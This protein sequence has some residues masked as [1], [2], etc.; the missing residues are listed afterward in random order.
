MRAL[1]NQQK[2]LCSLLGGLLSSLLL[3]CLLNLGVLLDELERVRDLQIALQS[4]LGYDGLNLLDFHLVLLCHLSILFLEFRVGNSNA[5]QLYNLLQCQTGLHLTLCLALEHCAE[6]AHLSAGHLEVL[7][8]AHALHLQ[9]VAEVLYNG[10][11][12]G[13]DHS[14]R[15]VSL[16]AVD[17]SVQNLLLE[18]VV[19]SF[20]TLCLQTL[21]DLLLQIVEGLAGVG[22]VLCELVVDLRQ[23]GLLNLVY[24]ALE[25][26]FLACQF[27]SVVL[28]REGNNYV[29]LVAGLAADQLILEARDECAGAQSQLVMLSLAALE[30]NAVYKALEVDVNGIV[31]LSLA[32][33][34]RALR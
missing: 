21:G 33:S 5:F 32:L 34:V 16:H 31:L 17:Y 15:N 8:K 13:V 10:V 20:L 26:S 1:G 2:L 3:C 18:S 29:L 6:C 11:N 30:R 23:D 22:N 27:L 24:L 19:S 28:L 9:T 14:S 12:L 25:G 4:F 7:L